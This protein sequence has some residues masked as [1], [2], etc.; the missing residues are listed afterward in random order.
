MAYESRLETDGQKQAKVK[1][2]MSIE[3]SAFTKAKLK[4]SLVINQMSL[5]K[6]SSSLI[7]RRLAK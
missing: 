3:R 5:N 7:K 2:L 4:F 6:T 1:G